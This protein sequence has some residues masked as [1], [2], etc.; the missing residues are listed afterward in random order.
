MQD[1]TITLIQA[2]LH[3]E[4]I[5]KNLTSFDKKIDQLSGQ[6]DLIALPEMFTTGFTMNSQ[7]LSEEMDGQTMGWLKHWA[8]TK[9][10]VITGSIIIKENN[11]YYNRLIWMKPDGSYETY[12]KR[13]LFRMMGEN[14][15]YSAGKEKKTIQVNGWKVCP[16]ICYDLRFPVWCRNTEDYDCILF[17]ANWPSA[18][19]KVWLDLL[20]AR[21]HE[22]Q[23][24]V[25]GLNRVGKDGNDIP[26]SGDSI[27]IDPIG[28]TI[29]KIES[30]K[31]ATKTISLSYQKLRD[32]RA[33]FPVKLDRDMFTLE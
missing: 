32:A 6:T 26:F 8:Q 10:C 3:W 12:D 19:K 15:Y 22:N 13:H 2:D 30:N 21:A 9:D 31:E 23:A 33:K 7:H 24:Y 14:N 5:A 11:N 1:L 27:A 28:H 17:L 25:V 29:A 4:S 18:R 20:T 16:L